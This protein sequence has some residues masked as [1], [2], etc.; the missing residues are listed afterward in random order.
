MLG[1]LVE[2]GILLVVGSEQDRE[3]KDW[4]AAWKWGVQAG[5]FHYGTRWSLWATASEDDEQMEEW[6]QEEPPTDLWI[7]HDDACSKV[8]KL[9]LAPSSGIF[10]TFFRRASERRFSTD[11]IGVEELAACLFS[12]FRHRGSFTMKFRPEL[13]LTLTPS[14]GAR[15][16]FE[17]YVLVRNV[18]GLE[19]G[20]YHYSGCQHSLLRLPWNDPL[21]RIS[22]GRLLGGQDWAD[23]GAVMIVMLAHLERTMS[24]YRTPGDYRSVL[25]EAGHIA[26]NILLAATSLGLSAVPVSALDYRAFEDLLLVDDPLHSVLYVVVIGHGS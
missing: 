18:R 19:V 5:L 7:S 3:D 17:G 11:P 10:D 13:P 8:V 16:P 21:E 24:R 26:Q 14:A 4:L 2:C 1:K 12:G 6:Q 9:P 23:G 25:F 22:F 15:N 20:E